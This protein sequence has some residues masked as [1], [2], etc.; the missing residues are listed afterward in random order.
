MADAGTIAKAVTDSVGSNAAHRVGDATQD[1]A[2]R[3][4][5]GLGATRTLTGIWAIV[6]VLTYR[7][8]PADGGAT[9]RTVALA[10]VASYLV[11]GLLFWT[12]LEVT[13]FRLAPE[14]QARLG[15]VLDAVCAGGITFLYA[16]DRTSSVWIVMFLIGTE[17]AMRFRMRGLGPVIALIVAV[18]TSGLVW[19]GAVHGTEV[20]IRSIVFRMTVVAVVTTLVALIS[21]EL[22]HQRQNAERALAEL[23]QSD[24][25]RS[26]LVATLGHDVRGPLATIEMQ[27]S[28]LASGRVP[29]DRRAGMLEGIV[30]QTTRLHRLAED[31]LEM[32]RS[33][34]LAPELRR[35]PTDLA[36]L[37]RQAADEFDEPI[38]V[39]APAGIVVE[40]D[41]SR[42]EQVLVNLLS[43]AVRHGRPPVQ[44]ALS[45]SRDEVH[46]D[47]SD[48]GAGLTGEAADELFEAFQRR[49]DDDASIGLGL[50]IVR[51][52]VEAHGGAVS[53]VPG[54][55]TTFRVTLPRAPADRPRAARPRAATGH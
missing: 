52:L 5:R 28:M 7:D 2:R 22:D 32:A 17:G 41:A 33:A 45:A 13:G 44:V 4:Q 19:A 46:L 6:M 24:R 18:Y 14:R 54:I 34:E 42:M 50:W 15:F 40:V 29:E 43:N 35:A 47:V 36:V 51:E 39:V 21:Q 3:T 12:R 38:E 11:V 31:L 53:L 16:F 27:A 37:V 55:G 8:Y 20:D 10:L 49:S 26:R 25:W 23:Q 1:T 30:R 48:A 9:L